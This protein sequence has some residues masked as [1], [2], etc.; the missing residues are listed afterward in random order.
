MPDVRFTIE[1]YYFVYDA[2]KGALNKQKH[3]ISFETAAY[4]FQDNLRLDFED[5]RH[6]TLDEERWMTIGLVKDVLTVVCCERSEDG[7]DYYRLISAR[8]ATPVERKLYND[9]VFGRM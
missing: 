8:Q 4:V 5:S 6:S 9:A 3:G 1:D 7:K 2:R